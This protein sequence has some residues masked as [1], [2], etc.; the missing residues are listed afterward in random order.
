MRMRF[1]VVIA[2]VV[3]GCALI[4]DIPTWK[5]GVT[6]EEYQKDKLQCEYEAARATPY[7]STLYE[8]LRQME[9]TALCMKARGYTNEPPV[10][11][12][13]RAG[14]TQDDFM[15]D[16]NTCVEEARQRVSKPQPGEASDSAIVIDRGTFVGC[17]SARGYQLSPT[18]TFVVP[19]GTRVQV[20]N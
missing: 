17:M 15:R 10:M 11:R 4:P 14:A 9:L 1:H 5:E 2:W 3:S 18:G 13:S 8:G 19:P 6:K 7:A 20:V 16:R 12:W